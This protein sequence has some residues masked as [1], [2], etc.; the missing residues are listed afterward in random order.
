MKNPPP[1]QHAATKPALRGPSRSTQAPNSAADDPRNTKNSVYIAPSVRTDQ[2]P[3]ADFVIPM[4]RL[5]GSQ[6][7]L[8]PYAMPIDKWTASAAGGTSQRLNDGEAIVRALDSTRA[9]GL[10][11]LQRL[12][13]LDRHFHRL[14]DEIVLDVAGFL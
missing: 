5:S 9:L 6:N 3:G 14:L 7:T 2:S 4:A 10:H 11:R 12:D 13:A 8:N 1:Q